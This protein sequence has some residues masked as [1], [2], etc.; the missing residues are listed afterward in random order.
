M[1]VKQLAIDLEVPFIKCLACGKPI[2]DDMKLSKSFE[3]IHWYRC[4]LE[5]RVVVYP[6][7]RSFHE[8]ILRIDDKHFS[9]FRIPDHI[10]YQD[11]YTICFLN[12][13][14]NIEPRQEY[15]HFKKIMKLLNFQ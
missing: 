13:N 12:A 11:K 9:Q 8:C 4:C 3:G 6:G 2:T 10:I 15:I 7:F 1:N 5:N 14:P